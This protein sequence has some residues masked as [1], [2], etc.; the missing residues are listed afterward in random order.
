M[1][2]EDAVLCPGSAGLASLA[3]AG[4]STVQ[5]SRTVG[6]ADP[7]R[8]DPNSARRYTSDTHPRAFR[9]EDGAGPWC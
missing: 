7:R 4:D 3:L 1:E 9:S 2:G 8:R 5:S 6:S